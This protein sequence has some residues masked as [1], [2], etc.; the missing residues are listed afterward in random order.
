MVILLI[1]L[2]IVLRIIFLFWY[3]FMV[4]HILK[5]IVHNNLTIVNCN[6][7]WGNHTF[8]IE[9]SLLLLF[10]IF[11]IW[12]LAKSG[13]KLVVLILEK[14]NIIFLIYWC[15][16]S[17]LFMLWLF[18]FINNGRMKLTTTVSTVY[19]CLS[20]GTKFILSLLSIKS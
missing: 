20:S 17:I 6:F 18:R 19:E 15:E 5:H 7:I 4:I 16:H 11:L 12:Q 2:T 1:I 9:F 8:S 3:L 10:L 14:W 13:F